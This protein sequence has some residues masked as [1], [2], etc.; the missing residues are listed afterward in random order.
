MR[1]NLIKYAKASVPRYTSYPTAPHFQAA[2]DDQVY[3]AQLAALTAA[4]DLSL[5]VHIPFCHQMC[6]YCGCHTTIPNNYDRA[7]RYCRA[8]E[9]EFAL[10]AGAIGAAGSVTHLHFGGGTPTYLR[11]ADLA[12]LMAALHRNFT[13]ATDAECAIEI[14][15]R[16]LTKD[17]AAG[18]AAMGINRA[19]LGVQDFDPAVQAKINRI[20]PTGQ[21]VQSIQDLRAAGIEAISFDLLYGLPG[22]TTNSVTQTANTAADL[23]PNRLS[24]FGYAHVPWFKKHQ[25][26]ILESELPGTAER[27]DQA[28]AIA[29]TLSQ[30]GYV[31]I[32]FDHF[33]HPDD[34][35]ASSVGAGNLQRNF[36]GYTTDQ[37]SV[38]LGFGASAIG[39]LLQGYVQNAPNIGAYESTVLAGELPIHRQIAL[40][41]EDAL[42][43]EAINQIMCNMAV[44][45][46]ALCAAHGHPADTLDDA[47]DAIDT[48]AADGLVSRQGHRITVLKPGRCFLRNIASAFDAY[49]DGRAGRHSQAV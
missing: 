20:Q 35:L 37:A 22:Q 17:Y 7:E 2:A 18:L 42:R 3:R 38:M 31:Q 21:V 45:L 12:G 48:M 13:L 49:L 4:Q 36:Q 32:G 25:Q 14:D 10:V 1:Q 30:H 15:P 34:P 33:A 8:L 19:S 39:S 5:Y 11:P 40:S 16:T 29:Q 41:A 46:A 44:D 26:M 24:V 27:L 9:T 47:L 23:G 28:E 6:W 43:R